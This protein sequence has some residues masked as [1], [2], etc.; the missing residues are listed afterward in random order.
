MKPNLLPVFGLLAL[1]LMPT[2][3]LAQR[4]Q[5]SLGR[6]VVAAQ[7]DNKVTVTWRRLAQEPEDAKYNLYVDRTGGGSYTKVA[8]PIAQNNYQA[9]LSAIPYGSR[10]AVRLVDADGTEGAL[11]A[12]FHFV[13][14]TWANAA[15]RINYKKAGSPVVNHDDTLFTSKFCW[16]V[17]LN[18]DGEMEYVVNRIYNHKDQNGYE[19]HGADKLGGDY[20]EAYTRDGQHLWTVSLGIHFFAFGGQ[21]DGVTVGD[22]DGDGRGEVCVQVCEGARLWDAENKCLGKYLYYNGEQASSTG[23]GMQTVSSDGSN[24]DIDGDGMTNY[25]YYNKGKN[26]QHYM[27]IIDGMTGEQKAVCPMTMPKDHA[28]EYTRT[29]KSAFMGDEYPYLSAAMGSAFLDGVHQSI[30]AQFQVRMKNGDHHY[31]TYAYGYEGGEFRE[32]FRFAF[33]DNGNPSEFHHIRIG[34]VDGDG[35]DEVMNGAY[36]LDNTGKMLWNSGIGHGDRFRMSDIDPDRPGQEIFA[37]QQNAP[38]MLGTI[39]Y[40]AFDGT[41]IKR[42]YM[43]SVGDVGRGECMDVDPKH[44]G[45]EMWSTLPNMYNAKGEVIS[46]EHPYPYEGMWWDDDLLREC[47]WTPGSGDNAALVI[48]KYDG[49]T[50]YTRQIQPSKEAEWAVALESGV[51][52]LFWGD[53]LGDW[54]EEIV[55]T[56]HDATGDVGFVLYTTNYTTQVKNIYCLLEDPNYF[57]QITNRG[58]YQSPNTSFYLGYDMP[59][60]PLPP[61]MKADETTAV[62]DLTLGNAVVSAPS[63]DIQN[64][65]FMP[66]REQTLTLNSPIEGAV[67]LWKGMQ[68]TLVVNGDITTTGKVVVSEGTL[69]VNGTVTSPIE[70]RARGVLS[71]KGTVGEISF[72]GSLN[73]AEGVI[74][75]TETLTVQGDL[76]INKNTFVEIDLDKGTNLQVNGNI[77]ITNALVFNINAT[78]LMEG[79]YRLIAY[80]DTFDGD[81]AN[82]EVRGIIGLSYEIVNSDNAIS[83]VIHGQREAL[84]NVHWTGN[85]SNVWDYQT[86]NWQVNG[87]STAFVAQDSIIFDD[88]TANTT[89]NIPELMPAASI[90]VNTEQTYTL[91]GNG[92]LTGEGGLVKNGSGKLILATKNADYTGATIINEGTVVLKEL[93]MQGSASSI[94][95][96]SK[97]AAKW[98][99]GKATM[100]FDGASL[101]TDRGIQLTD[102][103]TFQIPANSSTTLKGQITGASAGVLKKTGSGQLSVSYASANSYKSTI[104]QEG[105][106]AQGTTTATLGSATSEVHVTGNVK[107]VQFYTTNMSDAPNFQNKLNIDENKTLTF[108]GTGRGTF[109]STLLGKGTLKLSSDYVRFDNYMNAKDFEGTLELGAGANRF[110]QAVDM[111]K[112]TL[113]VNE[114]V[115]VTGY[116]GGSNTTQNF[117]YQIG[118]VQGAGTLGDGTWNIGYAGNDDSF[119]GKFTAPVNKYGEGCWTLTGSSTG[120]LNVYEGTVWANCTS[121]ATT[122][123]TI[124]V[125]SGATL[126]GNGQ[127]QNL[128]LKEGA[129]LGVL[130]KSPS[131]KTMVG[132]LTVN[133]N[134]TAE[135]GAVIQIRTRSTATKTNTDVVAVN[136]KATLTSPIIEMSELNDNYSYTPN[137]DI[138]IFKCAGTLSI[139]GEPVILP[140]KPKIGYRWDTSAL[141]EEGIIRVVETDITI[142]DITELIDLYL[143]GESGITIEDI[144]KLID[145]YLE[146]DGQHEPTL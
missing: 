142:E 53:I 123:G 136:G 111:Q 105:T 113:V 118:G 94:G 137:Q 25:T 95:V 146:A 120:A 68:G 38:D 81:V 30:V 114:D 104:F 90:E 69:E 88:I 125:H 87:E 57:G 126:R 60:P 63:S 47:A 140:A 48:G 70:L 31:F 16:P 66:V 117:T 129:T 33:W 59:R 26:P 44:K 122:S 67:N 8:G 84:A 10:L 91:Q 17:D 13:N 1:S 97:S 82:C 36:A 42:W 54:R 143:G 101:A 116:K 73:Y 37:I 2:E 76:T 75:P 72:E 20:L 127:V 49:G 106:I 21:N 85:A 18:G 138:Q 32:L 40:S 19:G 24:P 61:T 9:Q 71:G 52:P 45:Y 135:A 112:G 121:A 11:S 108:V 83:L 7:R 103:A 96:G 5:M 78:Q 80:T 99:V 23:S 4:Q 141:A 131:L 134:L 43:S 102:T 34:D 115:T 133:G 55:L 107:F 3:A 58:Y 6:G 56:E 77:A 29:N 51:R 92:G 39:L 144:T 130:Y 119:S 65:Y 15:L 109:R 145:R 79:T 22:F 64:A 62:Y 132:T 35:C 74:R 139:T 128:T 89:V 28:I 27:L 86:A 14:N 124:T 98:K 46:S 100:V 12:P 93:S 41:S 50:G 110:C